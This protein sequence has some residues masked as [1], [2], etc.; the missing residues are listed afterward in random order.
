MTPAHPAPPT[1]NRAR[2]RRAPNY[3][4][5]PLR[6]AHARGRGVKRPNARGGRPV[7]SGAS[8]PRGF[9]GVPPI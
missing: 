2:Q 4:R 7:Y 5:A 3:D 8:A 9:G 6:G 1:T